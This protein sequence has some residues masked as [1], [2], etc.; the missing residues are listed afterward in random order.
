MSQ[1][2]TIERVHHQETP[3][4]PNLAEIGARLT[5]ISQQRISRSPYPEVRK[6]QC[7]VREETV[8]LRG[9]VTTY[10]YK[11]MAQESVRSIEGISDIANEVEVSYLTP[12]R[13]VR[14]A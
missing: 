11:Q 2:L 14:S 4:L 3:I 5:R 9:T 12:S 10:Y 6:V 13:K 1:T 8:V 7:E